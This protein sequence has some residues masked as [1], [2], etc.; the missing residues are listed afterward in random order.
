M[1]VLSTAAI[2]AKY[3][4]ANLLAEFCPCATLLIP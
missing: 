2:H 3:V 4:D 1:V